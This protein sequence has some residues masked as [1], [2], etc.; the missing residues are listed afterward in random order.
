MKSFSRSELS[1]KKYINLHFNLCAVAFG[2]ISF[3][4]CR[5]PIVRQLP[6]I[7]AHLREFDSLKFLKI[8]IKISKIGAAI[9]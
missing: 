8:L 3:P 6:L 1:L 5:C 7:N 9:N 2:E 4:F